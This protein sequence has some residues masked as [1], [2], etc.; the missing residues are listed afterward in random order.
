MTTMSFYNYSWSFTFAYSVE[1]C[2]DVIPILILSKIQI[3][4]KIENFSELSE[5]WNHKTR[6]QPEFQRHTS[7]PNK[8][9]KTQ[10]LSPME[11]YMRE[12]CWP[13]NTWGTRNNFNFKGLLKAKRGFV[14]QSRTVRAPPTGVHCFH[15][16]LSLSLYWMLM[17]ESRGGTGVW[18]VTGR[19]GVQAEN[20]TC[21]PRFFSHVKQKL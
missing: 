12:R 11:E 1:G 5:S 18:E 13:R 14:C 10:T 17:N 6:K 16:L 4:N 15:K 19:H 3:K 9:W 2:K 7:H 20:T 21:F 8:R